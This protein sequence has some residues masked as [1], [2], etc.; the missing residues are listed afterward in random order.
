MW[1]RRTRVFAWSINRGDPNA[2]RLWTNIE[3]FFGHQLDGEANQLPA[4]DSNAPLD[5]D[6]F[7]NSSDRILSDEAITKRMIPSDN[8]VVGHVV[9]YFGSKPRKQPSLAY[10][11]QF[12]E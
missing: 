8:R 6:A 1:I 12:Y 5:R 4:F 10:T 3:E 9:K 7:T 2:K 11:T